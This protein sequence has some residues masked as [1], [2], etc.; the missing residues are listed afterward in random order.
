MSRYA[1]IMGPKQQTKSL[2]V[3]EAA[4]VEEPEQEGAIGQSSD[5]TASVDMINI[6]GVLE[7]C[8]QFQSDFVER[9]DEEKSKQERRWQQIQ[10]EVGNLR[11]DLGKQQKT[12][13]EAQASPSSEADVE[14]AFR[15]Q[16]KSEPVETAWTQSDIPKFEEGDDIE[17]YLTTFE[18]LA[19]PYRWPERDWAV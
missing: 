9:W 18:R 4:L 8:L 14:P 7:R 10:V 6:A 15:H 11:D 1:L 19:T 2:K 12:E 13:D 5:E 17:Q 16:S 3:A